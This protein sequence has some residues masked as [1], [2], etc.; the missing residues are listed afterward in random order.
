VPN[1]KEYLETKQRSSSINKSQREDYVRNEWQ[2]DRRKKLFVQ[3]G[4]NSFIRDDDDEIADIGCRATKGFRFKPLIVDGRL[5]KFLYLPQAAQMVKLSTMGWTTKVR[6]SVWEGESMLVP[7]PHRLWVH[8][9]SY[10]MA[11]SYKANR[12]P[13]ATAEIKN[14]WS[15]SYTLSFSLS[16]THTHSAV[17]TQ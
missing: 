14:A 1:R 6:F 2:E 7:R 10:P 9:L 15:F 12:S 11:P 13:P 8:P 3:K 17:L 5:T 16:L 4:T